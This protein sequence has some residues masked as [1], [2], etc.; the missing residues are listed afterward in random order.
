MKAI[1]HNSDKG[2]KNGY[3]QI[4]CSYIQLEIDIFNTKYPKQNG[5]SK[6][7]KALAV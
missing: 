1:Q 3:S 2:N 5:K 7:S 6:V 4:Q